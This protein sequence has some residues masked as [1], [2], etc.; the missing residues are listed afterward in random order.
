ME[1][2]KKSALLL[3][4]NVLGESA[5]HQLFIPSS[6]DRAV[7]SIDGLIAESDSG[8]RRFLR[9]FMP[10]EQANAIPIAVYNKDTKDQD[11]D[12]YLD[13]IRKENQRW[14]LVSDA[15]MPCVADPGNRVVFRARQLGITVQAFIGP[16]SITLSLMLSGLSGQKFVF[17]GYLSSARASRKD[18]IIKLANK[19]RTEKET[20][21]LIEAPHRNEAIMQD[22]LEILPED[23]YL[24]I[25]WDLTLQTQGGLTQLVSQWKKS[26]VPNLK[27]RAAIFLVG[28]P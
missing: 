18:Q 27:K 24:G 20:Q 8:G 12:F 15:G 21:I 4:P 14:G 25:F 26:P 22:L 2:E 19:S 6:V 9:R 11:I 3:L 7:A 28:M 16:S 17:H 5:H 10:V 23:L 13:P 1:N